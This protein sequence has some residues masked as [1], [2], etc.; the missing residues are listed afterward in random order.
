M[1]KIDIEMGMRILAPLG[2][3]SSGLWKGVIDKAHL[4]LIEPTQ[5]SDK[6]TL[7]SADYLHMTDGIVWP[8]NA[9]WS[10]T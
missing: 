4:L 7:A 2:G 5:V 10:V 6:T 9:A 3:G 8:W 1:N